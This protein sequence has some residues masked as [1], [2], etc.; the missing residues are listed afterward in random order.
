MNTWHSYTPD[1]RPL[2]VRF[3]RDTWAV[4]CG[5]SE[6]RNRILDVALIEAIRTESDLVLRVRETDYPAWIRAQADRIQEE[7]GHT[8]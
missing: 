5:A 8:A 1:G 3:E 2:V 6:T 4:R 7:L